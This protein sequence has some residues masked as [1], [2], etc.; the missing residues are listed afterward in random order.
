MDKKTI[1]HIVEWSI[2][3]AAYVYLVY[4]L[5]T[6]DQYE[7]VAAS[8]RAMDGGQWG[9]LALAVAL[10]P[11]NMA[12][13]AWKWKTLMN[14]GVQELTNERM[15]FAEAQRQVYYSKLA[16]LIT[17]WRLG[18]YPARAM[19][20]SHQNS[21]DSSKNRMT[22]VLA[23]GAVG[24]AT[25]T[26]AIVVTGVVALAFSPAV[27]EQVGGSYLYAL[28]GVVLV[29]ALCL[30]FAPQWLQK[31]FL[32][33]DHK[34][35]S[36]PPSVLIWKSL[37]QSAVRLGCWCVQLV[38]VL[39]ALGAVS[40]QPSVFS[41]SAIYYLLVT[42]TPNVPI[43]EVGVRGAWAMMLFGTVNAALAGVALWVIN[44]LLPC[45]IW[46]FFRKNTK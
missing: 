35:S 25:M 12:I 1:L 19:L 37:G 21:E 27:L 23:M 6:Y 32:G 8:L 3:G 40:I 15:T 7:A 42:V 45:V 28:M 5:V 20:M 10:M 38:L 39:Y 36:D 46:I 9:A 34:T 17:P 11:V 14:E 30:Y 16:G 29:L 44:T 13:E 4:R 26:M 22:K 33:Q 2:A 18:E 43:A 41:L 24:S 31:W